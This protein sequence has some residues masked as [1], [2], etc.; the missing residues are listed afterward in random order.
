M[1]IRATAAAADYGDVVAGSGN[2]NN[3]VDRDI[4]IINIVLFI[5]LPRLHI[6]IMYTEVLYYCNL[7]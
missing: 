5:S 4:R 6:H 7:Y 3:T 1:V 2:K